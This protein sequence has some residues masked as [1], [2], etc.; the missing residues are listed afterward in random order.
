MAQRKP[1][2]VRVAAD[3]CPACRKLAAEI[4]KPTVQDELARWRL[5]DVNADTSEDAAEKYGVDAIPA[6]RIRTP[7]DE[8]VASHDGTMTAAELVAWL[9]KY[10]D[11]ARA[12]PDEVLLESGEPDAEAVGRLVERLG[13]RNA[14]TREAAAR[15]LLAY[16]AATR[17]AVAAALCKGKLATRLGAL[18][19]LRQ[20]RA[21]IG[22]MDPWRPETMTA[23]R[24]GRLAEMVA[25]GRA[26]PRASP[27][28]NN[29]P[30]PTARSS[31]CS[32]WTTPRRKRSGSG[33]P[34]WAR[35][36]CRR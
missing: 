36:W 18:E 15:R 29:W 25:A 34:G 26:R 21:P 19:L 2:L 6:L 3:W 28:P 12:V 24:I 14:A 13:W 31:A 10:Y 35:R 30:R 11:E 5:V 33:W 7:E 4:A 32:R 9:E 17:P 27:R 22:D 23:A 1:V 8:P 20:W 16:P